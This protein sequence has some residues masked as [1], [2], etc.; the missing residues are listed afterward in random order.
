MTI[1]DDSYF[2]P[3][4][5][6]VGYAR[7]AAARGATLLA[8]TDVLAVNLSA[9]KVTGVTTA[10]GT[11]EGPIVVD[12]ACAWTRQVAEASG[13]R[14][15][16]A[17]TCQQLIVTEP[18]HGVHANL[19]MVRI[20]TL[21]CTC[22]RARAASFG[23]STKRSRVFSICNCWGPTSM[24]RTCRS[25]SRSFVRQLLRLRINSRSCK[26]LESE[27]FVGYPDNDRRRSP[28]SRSC[29]GGRRFSIS[30]ATAILL[31][32]QS[33]RRWERHC[34]SSMGSRLLISRR[35]L[36]CAAKIRRG[37]SLN[38]AEMRLGNIGTLYSSV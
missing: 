14:V 5:V 15:P 29:P 30:R 12:A 34:G 9:G 21:P 10:K 24:S 19:P 13:I 16:L 27:N 36:A 11:I 35:C 20:M 26:W 28:H 33:R 7:A 32:F 31:S 18:L 22:A 38:C 23:V 37:P 4:Q 17:P 25:T 3:A 6:A 2:D 8:K 1:G